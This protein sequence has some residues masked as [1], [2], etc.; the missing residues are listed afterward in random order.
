M[1]FVGVWMYRV[2]DK[3]FKH[4]PRSVGLPYMLGSKSYPGEPLASLEEVV[5]FLKT[6]NPYQWALVGY[7]IPAI[8]LWLMIFKPF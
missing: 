5:L 1:L 7:G 2:N 8:V 6:I 4:L 3:Q